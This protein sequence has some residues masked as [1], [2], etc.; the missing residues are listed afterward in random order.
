MLNE[1]RP[2]PGI[3]PGAPSDGRAETGFG[4]CYWELLSKLAIQLRASFRSPA[5]KAGAYFVT[6][7]WLP[8]WPGGYF[9]Y[10]QCGIVCLRILGPTPLSLALLRSPICIY[11]ALHPELSQIQSIFIITITTYLVLQLRFLAIQS[12]YNGDRKN[13]SKNSNVFI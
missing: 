2:P 12:F 10:H 4:M 9:L 8:G 7:F 11:I 1:L 6:W 3:L 13:Y 5:P